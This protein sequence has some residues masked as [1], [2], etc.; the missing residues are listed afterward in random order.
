MWSPRKLDVREIFRRHEELSVIGLNW[1]WFGSNNFIEQPKS[2]VQFFT[3]RADYNFKKYPNLTAHYKILNYKS[4]KNIVNTNKRISQ[5]QVH[6]ADVEGL[7]DNLSHRR[8]PRDPP[9]LLNHYSVQSREFFLNNKGFF[10]KNGIINRK[11]KCS[12]F[13]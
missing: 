10:C 12:Y 4:Q 3:K 2:V 8:Y 5:V 13:N 11:C 7:S 6:T 9:L 1:V